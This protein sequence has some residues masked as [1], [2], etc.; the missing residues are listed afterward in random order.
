MSPVAVDVRLPGDEAVLR[1][2]NGLGW[3]WLDGLMRL[4]SARWFGVALVVLGALWLFLRFRPRAG[5]AVAQLVASVGVVD[6]LGHT[7]LKPFWAR[8]RP[9]HAMADGVRLLVEVSPTSFSFP[10]LHAANAFAAAVAL[11]CLDRRAGRVALPVAAL[12]AL[13]RVFV[14]VHWPSDVVVG[15]IYGA[16]VAYG[17]DWLGRRTWRPRAQT[18]SVG[19]GSAM[20]TGALPGER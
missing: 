15:G 13:S 8:Q 12:I 6:F 14:G 19:N 20:G 18:G 10:S 3:G 5:W 1:A 2:C 11:W 7:L 9:C 16:A 4:A 17:L